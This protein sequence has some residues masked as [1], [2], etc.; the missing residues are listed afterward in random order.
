MSGKYNSLHDVFSCSSILQKWW[1]E[2]ML[3]EYIR[4]HLD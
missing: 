3:M 2:R 1:E 4:F